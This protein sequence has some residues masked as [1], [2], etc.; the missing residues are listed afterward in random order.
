MSRRFSLDAW[1][2]VSALAAV[3]VVKVLHLSVGW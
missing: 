1:A 3:L 2:V